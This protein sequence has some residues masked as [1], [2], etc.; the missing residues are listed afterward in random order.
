[1][2]P[3]VPFGQ[4]STAAGLETDDHLGEPCVTVLFQLRQNAGSEENFG[5]TDPEEIF[6]QIEF[7]DLKR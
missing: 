1:M 2:F 7:V 6:F 4:K 5:L 3:S